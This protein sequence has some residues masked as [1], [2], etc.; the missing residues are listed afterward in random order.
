MRGITYKD[1]LTYA[2]YHGDTL[3]ADSTTFSGGIIG[4]DVYYVESIGQF[5]NCKYTIYSRV[6]AQNCYSLLEFNGNEFKKDSLTFP[7]S[8][9]KTFF[10][11]W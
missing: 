8:E 3:N 2:A 10:F 5:W 4:Q 11:E 7:R 6:H 1:S 9:K